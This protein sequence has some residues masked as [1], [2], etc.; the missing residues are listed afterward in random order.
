MRHC[1]SGLQYRTDTERGEHARAACD[2]KP[3]HNPRSRPPRSTGF[4]EHKA[5]STQWSQP[6]GLYGSIFCTLGWTARNCR[7]VRKCGT[8]A[9]Q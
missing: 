9:G 6:K 2:E 1:Q 7:H 5:F 3:R 4:A 8:K